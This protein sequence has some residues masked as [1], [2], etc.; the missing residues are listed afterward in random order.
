M[1]APTRRRSPR[2]PAARARPHLTID[3][4][5]PAVDGGRYPVKRI[6]G[7]ELTV[8][9]TVYR[10]GHDQI[11]GRLRCCGPEQPSWHDVPLTYEVNIDRCSATVRLDRIGRWRFSVEAWTDRFESWRSDLRKRATGSQT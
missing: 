9:A 8:A 3:R 1:V 4:V 10:D 5:E 11:G 7:D 2:A 6:L